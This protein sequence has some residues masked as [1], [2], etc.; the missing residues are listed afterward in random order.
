MSSAFGNTNQNQF[1]SLNFND[2]SQVG[3]MFGPDVVAAL[4]QNNIPLD[5]VGNTIG[6]LGIAQQVTPNTQFGAAN[7]QF[8]SSGFT[9]ADAINMQQGGGG[10]GTTQQGP[11]FDPTKT[12]NYDTSLLGAQALEAVGLNPNKTV[13]INPTP[14][15]TPSSSDFAKSGVSAVASPETASIAGVPMPQTSVGSIF[16]PN[17][18]NKPTGMGRPTQPQN[19]LVPPPYSPAPQA[20]AAVMPAGGQGTL[21]AGA[22]PVNTAGIV[23]YQLPPA[24]PTTFSHPDINPTGGPN[25]TRPGLTAFRGPG[26]GIPVNPAAA[27]GIALKT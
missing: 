18:A 22:P 9:L 13:T 20:N 16:S 25:P 2:W 23:P 27:A 19:R 26:G 10:A 1:G 6:K 24:A 4:Q 3:N 5:Q 8:V 12:P 7:P 11:S 14:A 15:N 21:F 17:T